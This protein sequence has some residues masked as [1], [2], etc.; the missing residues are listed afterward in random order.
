MLRKSS[1]RHLQGPCIQRTDKYNDPPRNWPLR[2]PTCHCKERKLEWYGPL[3][4][5]K[6]GL[7]FLHKFVREKG[8]TRKLKKESS[9]DQYNQNCLEKDIA[10]HGFMHKKSI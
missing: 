5:K 3:I 10:H 9:T 8:A 4:Y 1:R 7:C 2:R 6:N